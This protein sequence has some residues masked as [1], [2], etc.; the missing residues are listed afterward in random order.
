MPQEW[1]VL[2]PISILVTRRARTVRPSVWGQHNQLH[3][4]GLLRKAKRKLVTP[5]DDMKGSTQLQEREPVTIPVTL[6]PRREPRTIRHFFHRGTQ[7]PVAIRWFGMT[8]LAGHLRHLVAAAAASSNFDLRDW[9]RPTDATVLLD[10][11][12]QVLGGSTS[13]GSL[14]ERLGRDIWI[15]FVADSGDDFEVSLAVGRM[16]F[17]EYTLLGEEQRVL[18][19][20]DL[21][22]F[23]GDTA[24]PVA[25][26]EELERRLLGPWNGVLSEHA[27]H[28]RRRVLLGIP[29]NH[30]WYDALDG[31]CRLFRRS[32]LAELEPATGS[33]RASASTYSSA[34][35][36]EGYLKRQLHLDELT[37]SMRLAE[38]AIE[39]LRALLQRSTVKSRSR[40][41]LKGYYSV[42]EASY[43]A[44]PLAPGLD[45]WGVDR[46]LREAD[47]R[48]RVFFSQRRAEAK[49]PRILFVAPE[50]ALAYGDPNEPGED[51]LK[52]CDLSL[53]SD[54]VFYLTGDIHHY[55]RLV[56]GRSLHVIAGGG[57]AFLHGSRLGQGSG[58][59]PADL[60]YPDRRTSQRLALGV[61]FRLAA[62]TAGFLPHGLFALIAALELLAR[63]RGPIVTVVFVVVLTLMVT[64]GLALA[65]RAR[66]QRPIATWSLSTLFGLALGLGPLAIYFVLNWVVPWLNNF[67]VVIL[68]Y[69]FIG[70]FVFGLFLLALEITGLDHQHAFAALGHPGFRH[71]VRICVHPNGKVEGFVIG[72]DDPISA[73]PPA[74]IDRF[75][76]D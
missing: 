12:S 69:M 67:A 43:W 36:V 26:P 47:F 5:V 58:T 11:V 40:L 64:V 75:S 4:V 57:G 37:E 68:L 60:V 24:Y 15:D 38:E 41:N 49:P 53:T 8:A 30:D 31:F 2:P 44:L 32:V 23:G 71:F 54:R 33:E 55:E 65:A 52:A 34:E 35:R 29:G 20:G 63:R 17:N 13:E 70:S 76:W 72:K 48:Q 21:L 18:P 6:E 10:R 45:L 19:R 73:D 3:A 50:P 27:D 16:L 56:V 62:G 42:Q 74:L 39:S 59:V 61:P 22:M 7:A 14:S 25:T 1:Y 46:Q 51:L 28:D 9:M 66:L